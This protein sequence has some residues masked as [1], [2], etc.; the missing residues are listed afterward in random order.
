MTPLGTDKALDASG[1]TN[2]AFERYCQVQNDGAYEVITAIKKAKMA[3]VLPMK[4]R[5]E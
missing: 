2:K 5:P 4:K 3:T 1:L